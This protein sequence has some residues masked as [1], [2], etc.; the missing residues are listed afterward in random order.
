MWAITAS[1]IGVPCKQEK[2]ILN[3]KLPYLYTCWNS[4]LFKPMRLGF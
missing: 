3:K 1:L 2:Q 4:L